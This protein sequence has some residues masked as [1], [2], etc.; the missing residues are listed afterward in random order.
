MYVKLYRFTKRSNSTAAP[1]E[2]GVDATPSLVVDGAVINDGK[3]SLAS[4]AMRLHTRTASNQTL[5]QFNYMKITNW[6]RYYFIDDWQ[7]NGDGTWTAFGTIDVLA[8]W[9]QEILQSGGYLNRSVSATSSAPLADPLYPPT[10]AFISLYNQ[11]Q[12]GFDNNP[13]NG[14]FVL[15]VLSSQNPNIG[16]VSYYIV[17]RTGL[18]NIVSNMM[19]TTSADAWADMTLTSD[20]AMKSMIDPMQYVVSCK[21]FPFLPPAG[22]SYESNIY[23]GG[24]NTQSQGHKL[25]VG[26]E[27][28]ITS[29]LIN[30][31]QTQLLT[32]TDGGITYNWGTWSYITIPY[33][34]E[35]KDEGYFPIYDGYIN[36]TLVT[37]W[38][39]FDIPAN[40]LRNL[41]LHAS[42][43]SPARLY[44]RTLVDMIT[45]DG[46][47][48]IAAWPYDNN[49]S[50]HGKLVTILKRNIQIAKDIPLTQVTIN[51][52]ALTKEAVGATTGI[53][54]AAVSAF[55]GDISGFTNG[56]NG[57]VNGVIDAH[58]TA[59]S[60]T[61]KSTVN[62]TASITEDIKLIQ[63]EEQR[64]R[65]LQPDWNLTGYLRKVPVGNL[66]GF[67]GYVQMD[68][69]NFKAPC[70]ETEKDRVIALL[71]SG[72]YIE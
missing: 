69:S 14:T 4:P 62:G 45:G 71:G 21:W 56:I 65:T 5:T 47:F 24:W 19:A 26:S 8:T 30:S 9:K 18:A 12:S 63:Y 53:L 55:T 59:N 60:P 37:P 58:V 23:L 34:A 33:M 57:L 38:G 44:Y 25:Y 1:I 35:N 10:T 36:S 49:S 11:A 32:Q 64:Y 67:S 22:I 68:V 66:S 6:G 52:A 15:G 39:V 3:T 51:N 42:S 29:R 20:A 13:W 16:A 70:T 48:W 41:Y 50:D 31:N 61:V 54:G 7:Y 27:Q 72:V 28:V 17:T 2:S 46:T 40:I 43:A